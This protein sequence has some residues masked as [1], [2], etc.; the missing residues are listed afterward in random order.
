MVSEGLREVLQRGDGVGELEGDGVASGFAEHAICGDQVQLS[1][2]S[3]DGTV[4]EVR[5]R[6]NGCPASM[7]IA[8]LAAE[9]LRDVA[10]VDLETVLHEAITARGGLQRHE[11]HAEKMVLR[12]L[13]E[14]LGN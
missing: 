3:T 10:V 9:V 13:H 7:A 8:A 6:A 11:H 5:W 2:R 14:A 4:N 1:V 12:A